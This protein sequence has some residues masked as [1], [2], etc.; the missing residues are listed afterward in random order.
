MKSLKKLL[1]IL[2]FLLLLVSCEKDTDLLCDYVCYEANMDSKTYELA[3]GSKVTVKSSKT[4][5]NFSTNED[6]GIILKGLDTKAAKGAFTSHLKLRLIGEY[7]VIESNG[8]EKNTIGQNVD[9]E[10]QTDK[11]GD[12][13]FVIKHVTKPGFSVHNVTDVNLK[14]VAKVNNQDAV[15]GIDFSDKNLWTKS[16]GMLNAKISYDFSSGRYDCSA[17]VCKWIDLKNDIVL[18]AN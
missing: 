4:G 16:M 18:K 7:T 15:H 11:Y 14:I 12:F 3:I 2:T 1:S 10:A 8:V 17:D 5:K 6:G 13:F 9:L